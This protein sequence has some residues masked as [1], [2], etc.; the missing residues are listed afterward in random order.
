MVEYKGISGSFP[1]ECSLF[2]IARSQPGYNRIADPVPRREF[3][4]DGFARQSAALASGKIVLP[5]TAA[6]CEVWLAQQLDPTSPAYNIGEYIEIH[7]SLDIAL[8][9]RALRQVIDEA[10]ALQVQ[11]TGEGTTQTLGTPPSW[12]L[13]VFDLSAEPDARG[14][15]E[16]WMRSDIARPADLTCGP[17]FGFAL[18]KASR[19]RFFWYARYHHILMDGYSMWLIARRLS[20]VYT[21]LCAGLGGHE[22]GFGPLLHLSD[23]DTSYRSGEALTADRRFWLDYLSD[24][25]GALHLKGPVTGVGDHFVRQTTI[26]RQSTTERMRALA[27]RSG[28]RVPEVI[29][30]A[31]AMLL[32]RVAAHDDLV[33]GLAVANRTGLSRTI[34]GMSSNVIPVRLAAHARA[35]TLELVEQTARKIHDGLEHRRYRLAELRRDVGMG[36]RTLCSVGV[37]FMRFNYEFS[38]A[39]NPVTV[40]NL[41]LGPVEELSVAVYERTTAGPLRVDFDGNPELFTA[42][43]L[44]DYQDRFIRLLEAAVAEPDRAIGRL[45]ILSAAERQTIVSDWNATARPLGF[46]NI[47]ELFAAQAARTPEAT[48]VVYGDQQLSYGE[49]DARANQLAHH[50]RGLGVGPEV[51]VGLCVERSLEMLVGVLGILKAGG[52][53]LPLD[54]AY[55]EERLAFMLEDARAPVL[56]TQAKLGSRLRAPGGGIVQLDADWPTI[57]RRP[58]TASPVALHPHNTAYVIYTSGSTGT[59]KGVAVSHGGIPNLAAA[60]I[61]RFAITSEARVLQFA[62]PSFDAAISEI[63]TVLIAGGGLILTAADERGGEALGHVIRSQGV[64]HATLPPVVLGDLSSDVPL[65]TLVVAGDACAPALI[66]RWSAG[67]RMINAYGP[68]ETTV[69]AT[70]SEPLAADGAAPIGRP[71][72]N[73]RVYVLDGGLEP[74]AVGVVGELYI[75][76]AGLARGYLHRA[77]LTAERFV[78]DPFGAAGSRMYRTGDLARWRADG[79]LE[80]FGRADQQVKLRGFRIEP[81][82]I[83]AALLR[84]GTVAQA[85]VIAREDVPGQKRLVGYVVAAADRE[86]DTAALRAQLGA[87][88]PDYMVPSALVVL[89]ALPLT[90]NGKLDRRALPAPDL[91]PQQVRPPRTPQEEVLCSLYAEVLGVE[92]VGIDDNFFALGGD[93]IMSIQLVS[94][95]R[96]AGLEI[97]PRAVFQHQT[98]EALAA[99]SKAA[100][101]GRTASDV[102]LAGLTQGE[103][104]RLEEA[105]PSLEDILPLSPLQEGLLFHALYD[106]AGVDLYTMQIAFAV[107]GPLESEVLRAAAAVL[108]QRHASLRAAFRHEQLSRPVQVVLSPVEVPFRS[109][110]LSM[111]KEAEREERWARLLQDDR[112]ERF[113]VTAPPLLRFT[114]VRLG[115]DRHRLLFT[116]P[117]YSD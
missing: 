103:L 33:F 23:Q 52:A 14:T 100:T 75:S 46:A 113:D 116:A 70:M 76:G 20:D 73:T 54:P 105:Y 29:C 55:P 86:I 42:D 110:D 48:A 50:L 15:A 32:H 104:E 18:F 79:V 92:R 9:E 13:P 71:I 83:E 27:Q 62:S 97:T 5:L 78:A 31:V 51:V 85:A 47:P 68:T 12:S 3:T 63:A 69:C 67:R 65:R 37:N 6:Q 88:L 107:E 7:G 95:A 114:L 64:T 45:D 59:P 108:V 80:F 94:R 39:G 98:V 24:Q 43:E 2:E 26:L 34:P 25:N 17:L 49:L 66:E 77:A 74:V 72:W 41:S 10:E 56:L 21:Q 89:E 102:P 115:A 117:P 96:Q 106:A 36:G 4:R 35:T 90:A 40:H 81:G 84:H 28:T 38:F 109:V 58:A 44:A 16:A 30:A 82:E 57:A 60:Q 112:A 101:D 111:L 61:D 8:F 99:V 11:V 22:N 87:S 19:Q 1:F 93:S 53:Y 91:T